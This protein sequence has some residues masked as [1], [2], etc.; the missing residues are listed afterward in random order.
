MRMRHMVIA[1]GFL[2]IVP[3]IHAEDHDRSPLS[4]NWISVQDGAHG[5][6]P[7]VV[8]QSADQ[9]MLTSLLADYRAWGLPLPPKQAK[10]CTLNTWN[11]LDAPFYGRFLGFL[12]QSPSPN[13]PCVIM[14]GTE[15]YHSSKNLY[16]PRD[17]PPSN[18]ATEMTEPDEYQDPHGD[19]EKPDP[20]IA[21]DLDFVWINSVWHVNV[22]LATAIQCKARGYDQLALE[23]L[24]RSLAITRFECGVW[25]SPF[26]QPPEWSP[27]SKLALL[28]WNHWRNELVA[29]DTDRT[30]ILGHLKQL[31][32][33]EPLLN[34]GGNPLL[35]DSLERT[36]SAARSK[37]GTIEAAFDELV[38]MADS[39]STNQYASSATRQKLLAFKADAIPML[40]EHLDDYRL[41][42]SYEPGSGPMH[43]GTPYHWCACDIASSLL[44]QLAAGD[45]DEAYDFQIHRWTKRTKALTKSEA[46]AWYAKVEDGGEAH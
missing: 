1:A 34:E 11:L 30:A 13:K 40:I 32:K 35:I 9:A 33:D 25:R 29:P 12:L 46:Q 31:L 28:A 5:A 19:V 8:D 43:S 6:Q 2:A 27:R 41:T 23:L 36:V 42:R 14:A 45:L 24:H 3:L 10:L 20:A 17:I 39:Q 38:D 4:N 7:A 22:G 15:I 21:S 37:P 44:Q 18:H 16:K 26:R